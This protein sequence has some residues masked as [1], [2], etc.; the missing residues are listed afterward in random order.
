MDLEMRL[1]LFDDCVMHPP[2]A[3]PVYPQ[4]TLPVLQQ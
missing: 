4:L 1:S 3:V 2:R